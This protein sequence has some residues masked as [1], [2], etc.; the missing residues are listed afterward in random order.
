MCSPAASGPSPATHF[1][2]TLDTLQVFSA[3]I[4]LEAHTRKI[5]YRV[6]D[7]SG[8]IQADGFIPATRFDLGRPM[9]TLPQPSE[10][11]RLNLPWPTGV[12]H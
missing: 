6:K 7:S 5:T 8:V 11:A 9:K 3:Y 1:P 10:D 2:P 12:L 4:G